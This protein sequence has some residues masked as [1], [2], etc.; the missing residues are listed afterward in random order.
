MDTIIT[1]YRLQFLVQFSVNQKIAENIL[2]LN[3]GAAGLI[4]YLGLE[5]EDGE[6]KF[7]SHKMA[8]VL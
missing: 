6:H 2:P 1:I 4:E 5:R 8:L 3:R 7:D